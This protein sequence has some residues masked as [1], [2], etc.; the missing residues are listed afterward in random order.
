MLL[1]KYRLWILWSLFR[2]VKILSYLHGRLPFFQL[3]VLE[4]S[5]IQLILFFIQLILFIILGEL[6]IFLL[7]GLVPSSVSTLIDIYFITEKPRLQ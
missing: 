2:G 3:S 1:N 7:Q 5:L 4:L 6:F